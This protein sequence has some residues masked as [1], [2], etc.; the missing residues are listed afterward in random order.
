MRINTY[1]TETFVSS[2]NQ[3]QP[4]AVTENITGS[5]QNTFQK[6]LLDQTISTPQESERERSANYTR[7]ELFRTK[8]NEQKAP[9]S[10]LAINGVITYKGVTFVCD[11]EKKSLCL[12][13]MS[14]PKKVLTISLSDG[15]F[16]KVNRENLGDLSKAIGMFSPE[17][18]NLILRA[19]AQDNKVQQTQ[20][21]I[22]KAGDQIGEITETGDEKSTNKE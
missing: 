18:V 6:I 3:N 22:S 5:E 16:L 1:A 19:I 10:K 13:D 4:H 2:V 11:H 20:N 21:E 15:G 8:E 7:G 9:Y 12:G 17:D 14:N